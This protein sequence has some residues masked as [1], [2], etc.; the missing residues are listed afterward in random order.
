[1]SV[2]QC[3]AVFFRHR[4]HATPHRSV[5]SRLAR[6]IKDIETLSPEKLTH[7][8]DA[9]E[10]EKDETKVSAQPTGQVG[11]QYLRAGEIQP[12]QDMRDGRECVFVH[13]RNRAGIRA[14]MF[15]GIRQNLSMDQVA[16]A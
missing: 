6:Q 4:L 7:R 15:S 9:V 11:S 12:V 3:D 5:D 10:A 1:M 13:E 8:P 16:L 2:E 14:P